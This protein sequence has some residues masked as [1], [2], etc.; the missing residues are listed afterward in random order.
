MY[1]CGMTYGTCIIPI[2]MAT[3]GGRGES[4]SSLPEIGL[5][6]TASKASYEVE[7][8]AGPDN[9]YAP[10]AQMA[11]SDVKVDY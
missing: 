2:C 10:H 8:S 5:R 7:F 3:S 11:R 9:T 6:I 1:V 4:K